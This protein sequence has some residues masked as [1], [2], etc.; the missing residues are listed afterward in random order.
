MVRINVDVAGY[1]KESCKQVIDKLI[2]MGYNY[3]KQAWKDGIN[4]SQNITGQEPQWIIG[5]F[6]DDDSEGHCVFLSYDRE[7]YFSEEEQKSE[8][9]MMSAVEFLAMPEGKY[10]V[11]RIKLGFDGNV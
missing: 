9:I 1:S 5:M 10:K 6:P 4:D 3:N 2:F 7:L 8:K 11:K